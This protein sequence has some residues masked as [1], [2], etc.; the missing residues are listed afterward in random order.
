MPDRPGGNVTVIWLPERSRHQRRVVAALY[1]QAAAVPCERR[2]VFAGGLRG[3]DKDGA[4]AGAAIDRSR[5]FAISIDLVLAE[6]ARRSLIPVVAGVSP[7]EGADLV[8]TEAQHIAKRLAGRAAADGRNLLL[9]VTMGS[10][11]SVRSWLVN[12][13]LAAYSVDVVIATIS[14]EDAA[15]WADAE[16]RRGHEEYRRGHGNGGH[17]VPE[18][19][20]QAAAL[21]A[22]A[23]AES[24]WAAILQHVAGQQEVAFPRGELLSLARAYRDGRITLA[25]I[26][27]QLRIRRLQPVPPACPPG[28]DDA[29][30]A[31]DDLEPWA[32]GSF[33][34]IVFA[35][36]LGLLS[37]DDYATIAEAI[38]S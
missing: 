12:L 10:E 20:I 1:E 9:D 28:L 19:A 29:K 13:G 4:L 31:L 14:S 7:M 11:P 16:H 24:D 25:D 37:D 27:A 26:G 38:V 36:D 30:P 15:R 18:E 8:H 32:A 21:L 6:L 17:Y 34:E 22:A 35:C 3:A 2:A 33:D 23:L 5:Y